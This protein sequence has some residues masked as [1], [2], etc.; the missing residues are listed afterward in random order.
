MHSAF[1]ALIL[2]AI[3]AD[4]ATAC[5]GTGAGGMVEIYPTAEELPA[6]LLRFFAYFPR[7]MDHEAIPSN[8]AL[9]DHTGL[10]VEGAFLNNRY[11]LWSPDATRLTILLD[12]GR[13]K[14]GLAAHNALG[15]ALSEGQRYTLVV[16]A[17]A[18][19]TQG[20]TLGAETTQ[21][22]IVG[23]PDLDPP[24]PGDWVLTRPESGTRDPLTVDLGS[25]HDHLSMVYRVRVL[26]AAGNTVPG[27]IDLGT[28]ERVWRFT[29]V[30]PW[31]DAPHRLSIDARLE[32][33]AGNRPGLLFDRPVGASAGDWSPDLAWSPS[34]A[35]K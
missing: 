16:R 10:E 24:S 9:V 11:D 1:A 14:T 17:A 12:P 7:P 34:R 8:I 28:D 32:D 33:L 30:S 3:A 29:P 5:P 26:D 20:C 31:P 21:S 18:E 27:R 35:G 19:D 22:F 25:P 23:P 2:A 6:N 13:V 4:S 15:R